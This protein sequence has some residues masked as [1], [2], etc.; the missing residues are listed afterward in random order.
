M[1]TE[2]IVIPLKDRE[3]VTACSREVEVQN[4]P[5]T[6]TFRILPFDSAER[7]RLESLDGVFLASITMRPDPVRAA[8]QALR[9]R[10][11]TGMHSAC[12][13][14]DADPVLVEA[15]VDAI[16][17]P[18]ET[19]DELIETVR[20]KAHR[21]MWRACVDVVSQLQKITDGASIESALVALRGLDP[22]ANAPAETVSG[23]EAMRAACQAKLLDLANCVTGH[24]GDERRGAYR[25]G[26]HCLNTVE[27][28]R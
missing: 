15:L 21:Y 17:A 10:I 4:G 7:V 1:S 8:E 23:G 6:G 25:N 18:D 20:D 5:T 26:A 3:T 2:P 28:P 24:G 16:D 11:R 22:D 14:H 13:C 19:S 27:P 12:D 9:E